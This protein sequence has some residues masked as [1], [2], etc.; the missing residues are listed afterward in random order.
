MQLDGTGVVVFCGSSAGK[1]PVYL[2]QASALGTALARAR[3]TVVYGGASVGL[4]G[5][6]ADAA[7]AAGGRVHGVIPRSLQAREIAHKGLTT[8]DVVESMH[9]RKAR[10]SQLGSAYVALPG[11]FGT[12]EEFF[13]VITWK[14]IGLHVRPIIAV[15]V[16]DYWGPMLRQVDHAIAEGFMVPAFRNYFRVAK[17]AAHAVE[18]LAGYDAPAGGQSKFELT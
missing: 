13:E 10:M 12:L 18:L 9:E 5:A 15:N 8:L 11:G 6:V 17:D 1:D 14:Q 4:M 16:S 2:Q 3:A 7:L